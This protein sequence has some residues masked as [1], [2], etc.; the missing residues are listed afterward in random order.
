MKELI[1]VVDD[2]PGI[3]TSL[4]SIIEDEGYRALTAA[5]GA[6]ALE[7]FDRERPDVV[8]LDIWLPDQDGLERATLKADLGVGVPK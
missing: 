5:T 2:E 8:L 1:L 6:R 7:L 3:L 4:A